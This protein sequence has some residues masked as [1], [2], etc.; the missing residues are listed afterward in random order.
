MGTLLQSLLMSDLNNE[1]ESRRLKFSVLVCA[2]TLHCGAFSLPPSSC[3]FRDH[4]G[5][6][7]VASEVLR[8]LPKSHER[9]LE[10]SPKNALKM[11]A[12]VGVSLG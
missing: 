12:P 5:F 4:P 3:P 10:Q 1:F 7:E 11:P 9:S 6:V 8:S 2:L